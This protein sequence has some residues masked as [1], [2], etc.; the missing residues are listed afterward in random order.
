MVQLILSS[1]GC[2]KPNAVTWSML[3]MESGLENKAT[4]DPSIAQNTADF[5]YSIL[6]GPSLLP[7]IELFPLDFSVCLMDTHRINYFHRFKR[8]KSQIHQIADWQKSLKEEEEKR[9]LMESFPSF[10]CV[11]VCAVICS[12]KRWN[13]RNCSQVS[14][15]QEDPGTQFFFSFFSLFWAFA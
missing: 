10:R 1:C 13:S 14:Q 15:E 8:I 6:V 5:I 3:A 7:A 4:D 11:L 9:K 2:Q 12:R